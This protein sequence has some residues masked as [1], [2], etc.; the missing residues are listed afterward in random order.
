[1]IRILLSVFSGIPPIYTSPQN[2]VTM[3]QAFPEA[4]ILIISQIGN[5][6]PTYGAWYTNEGRSNLIWQLKR[7][8]C[9]QQAYHLD[10]Y[11]NLLVSSIPQ[12]D[13]P[14]ISKLDTSNSSWSWVTK[15]AFVSLSNWWRT[16]LCKRL[17]IYSNR[18]LCAVKVC[19]WWAWLF[20]TS[21]ETLREQL[22]G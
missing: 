17:R 18:G 12:F 21:T 20:L 9:K 8:K 3:D 2:A 6:K 11:D 15:V 22:D 4:S 13:A 14:W 7:Y 5:A 10:L 16:S 19:F 1:M